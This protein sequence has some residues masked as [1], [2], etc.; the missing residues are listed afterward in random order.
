MQFLLGVEKITQLQRSI[1]G[2]ILFIMAKENNFAAA[3]LTFGQLNALVKKMGGEQKVLDFLAG[4]LLLTNFFD[5]KDGI[6]YLKIEHPALITKSEWEIQ[7]GDRLKQIPQKFIRRLEIAQSYHTFD[8]IE[9]CVFK[10]RLDDGEMRSFNVFKPKPSLVF[11]LQK[12]IPDNG[13]LLMGYTELLV[14]HEPISRTG[15]R[16]SP[17]QMGLLL[18]GSV[19]LENFRGK[20]ERHHQGTGFVYV[21]NKN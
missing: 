14:M 12:V 19:T 17:A 3:N 21:K 2:K 6:V 5:Y 11:Q 7:L 9:V 13:I 8:K 4:R 18:G 15:Y 16:Q 1:M 10:K 20:H